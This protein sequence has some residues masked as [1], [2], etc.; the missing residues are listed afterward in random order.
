MIS[1]GLAEFIGANILDKTPF[2]VTPYLRNGNA[3]Q[4]ISVNP[5][6]DLLRLLR[7]ISQGIAYLHSRKVV[8]GD[9]KAMNVL[10]D[11]NGKAVLC[12]FGL[13][14]VKADVTSHTARL[15]TAVVT[16][17]R[18]WMAPERLTGGLVTKPSDIYA[19]GMVV[20]EVNLAFRCTWYL[21]LYYDKI[22]TNKNPLSHITTYSDFLKRVVGADVRP[23]KP[24]EEEAPKLC[25]DMWE[26]ARRCWTKDPLLRPT[27]ECVRETISQLLETVM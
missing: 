24:D 11:D 18:N 26:L 14:R 25:D 9:M 8:H 23:K 13:S 27:A 10:I 21:T 2:I 17:S 5:E 6:C 16:G 15:G 12:D 4:Y 3:R 20:Y 22:Y 1:G 7:D 19:F